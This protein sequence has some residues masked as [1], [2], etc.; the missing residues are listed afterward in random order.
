VIAVKLP[1]RKFLHLAA[2][3]A[4]LP[5]VSRNSW[6]Q[7]WPARVIRLLVGFPPG[8]GAD[9]ASRI[10]AYRLSEIWG[11]QV[12]V[13]NRGGAGGNIAIDAA[14]HASPDGYTMVLATGAPA[15]YGLLFGSLNYDPVADLA[16]VSL[17]GTYPNLLVVSNSSPV[18]SVREY[19]PMPKPI[20]AR[21][22]SPRLEW[23]RR[24]ISPPNCSSAWPNID[25]THVPYRG[26][27][28]GG[29][30][31]LIAGRVDSMFNTTGSLLQAVKSDQVRGLAVTSDQRFVMAPDIPT[32]AESGVPG[33][34]VTSWYG[35]FVPAK[36]P[37]PI[38]Q[39][40][41][42]DIQ[43]VLDEAAIKS[44]FEP[45]GVAVASSTP[46]ELAARARADTELWGP[47]IKAANIKVN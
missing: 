20:R 33:Y 8:G 39:K 4:A 10:V 1:R 29:M 26:V 47:I 18:R 24:P 13:E 22:R 31:D 37:A 28:A 46:T 38:M 2:G 9:A 41:H 5:A 21:S 36:T 14:A 34:S 3:A 30:T 19:S 32:I 42:A 35:I 45:L 40:M 15:I 11:Q 44:R 23:G 7:S 12:V 27:A 43:A 16:P 25:I 17:I 6:A